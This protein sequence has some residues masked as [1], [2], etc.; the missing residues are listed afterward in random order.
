MNLENMINKVVAYDKENNEILKIENAK[1]TNFEVAQEVSQAINSLG[2]TMAQFQEAIQAFVT[3][4]GTN[5]TIC[6]PQPDTNEESASPNEKSDLEFFEPKKK[7][8]EQ[9]YFLPEVKEKPIKICYE[10]EPEIKIITDLPNP[11]E[12]ATEISVD[13]FINF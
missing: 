2:V 11:F 3:F 9:I 4:V 8:E 10:G 1:L 7:L 5:F 12:I 13:K 6:L